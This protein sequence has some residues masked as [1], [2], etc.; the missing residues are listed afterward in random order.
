M[1]EALNRVFAAVQCNAMYDFNKVYVRLEEKLLMEH[2][3]DGRSRKVSILTNC[4]RI[5]INRVGYLTD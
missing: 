4:C 3:G 2:Y 5:D 1:W